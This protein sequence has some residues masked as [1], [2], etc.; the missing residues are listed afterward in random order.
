VSEESLLAAVKKAGANYPWFLFARK[1]YADEDTHGI[2]IAV[3]VRGRKEPLYL[4]AKSSM[5]KAKSFATKKRKI[6][7]EVVVVSLNDDW[8]MARAREAL[9]RAYAKTIGVRGID[10]GAQ[11]PSGA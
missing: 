3:Y 5:G 2:D 1:A 4:Q 11:A 10:V 6:H 8:T 7:I 9:E